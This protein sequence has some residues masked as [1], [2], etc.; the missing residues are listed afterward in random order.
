MNDVS[1]SGET[2]VE[3]LFLQANADGKLPDGE[4][5][6]VI[7][8]LR[9]TMDRMQ[10]SPEERAAAEA[11]VDDLIG[12]LQNGEL[13]RESAKGIRK[14]IQRMADKLGEMRP[15]LVAIAQAQDH[16]IAAFQAGQAYSEVSVARGLLEV[17]VGSLEHLLGECECQDGEHGKNEGDPTP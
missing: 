13:W 4:R 1:N 12:K 8:R 2:E 15:G 11:K 6:K 9:E 16:G 7:D 3:G 14:V 10:L 5:Q 17:A